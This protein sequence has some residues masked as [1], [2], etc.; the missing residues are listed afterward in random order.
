MAIEVR[1]QGVQKEGASSKRLNNGVNPEQFLNKDTQIYSAVHGCRE[2]G[3]EEKGSF[4]L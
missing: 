4:R 2:K 1:S 3:R